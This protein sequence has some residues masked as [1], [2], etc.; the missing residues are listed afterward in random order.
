MEQEGSGYDR[1][2]ET[3]LLS[4]KR[5]PVVEEGDD[6]VTVTVHSRIL[7][8][9]TLRFM[10]QVNSRYELRQRELI[11]LGLLAQHEALSALEFS[12]LLE[13]DERPERIRNWLG[14]LSDLGLIS[15]HGKTKA[16]TYRIAHSVLRD[17]DFDGPTTLKGIEPHRLQ[18]HPLSLSLSLSIKFFILLFFIYRRVFMTVSHSSRVGLAVV[19]VAVRRLIQ[20]VIAQ[21]LLRIYA[22]TVFSACR[23]WNLRTSL[24]L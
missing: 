6:R 12:R 11:A 3:L 13:L 14:R 18:A 22:K 17:N 7:K 19:L 5:P 8:T 23:P 16:T 4:A 24:M 9:E 1:V 15:S 21:D 20:P 10:E 2:Y